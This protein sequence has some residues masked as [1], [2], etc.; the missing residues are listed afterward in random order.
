MRLF[1]GVH[2]NHLLLCLVGREG[3]RRNSGTC[4]SSSH[5]VVSGKGTL[6]TG[7]HFYDKREIILQEHLQVT[8]LI[9]LCLGGSEVSL[10]MG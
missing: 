4:T 5:A 9:T 10:L 2:R 1:P 6:G 3:R 8:D 7:Y